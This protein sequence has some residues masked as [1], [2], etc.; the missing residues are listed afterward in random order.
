MRREKLF[1]ALWALILGSLLSCS[2]AMCPVTA[3]QLDIDQGTL[4]CWCLGSA[5][6]C[7]ICFI[8][9]LQPLPFAIGAVSLGYLLQGG[10]LQAGFDAVLNRLSRQY[11]RAYG[12]KILQWSD[13][14]PVEMEP[15]ILI[16]LCIFGALTAMLTAWSVCRRK[17][18]APALFAA[19]IPVGTCFVVTDTVPA[20]G[21]LYLAM[22][23]FLVLLIASGCRK[24]DEKEGNRLM[25]WLLPITALALLVLLAVIPQNS[26]KGQE[27]AKKLASLFH[28]DPEQLL[29]S[30]TGKP[31][32]HSVTDRVDLQSI[33]YRIESDAQIMQVTAPFTGNLYLRG[34]ALDVYDGTSWT[35]G[36]PDYGTLYWPKEGME[37]VGEVTVSTRY[38]HRMLYMPYYSDT[39]Q[40]LDISFGMDND[41]KLNQYSFQC[42][43]PENPAL[44]TQYY[45]TFE[46]KAAP[47]Q[48]ALAETFMQTFPLDEAVLSWSRP[49]A[50]E[51][52][53]PY[54]SPYHKALAISSY[55][56]NSAS[57]NTK[58]NR[59]P[60]SKND[61]AQWFLEESE[62]GYCV[63]FATATVV[64]LQ[65]AG[66]PARYVTG[67]LVPVK[68]GEN[69]VVQSKQSHAWA[70]YWLPGHGWT[71][72]E[73][74]PPASEPETEETTAPT[75]PSSPELEETIPIT[76][77]TESLPP[78]TTTPVPVSKNSSNEKESAIGVILLIFGSIT[79]VIGLLEGQRK[80]RLHSRRKHRDTAAPNDLALLYWAAMVRYSK[81]LKLQ[82][83]EALQDLAQLAKFSQHTVSPEQLDRFAAAEQSA[84][85]ELQRQSVFLRL[86]YRWIL[87]LY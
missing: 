3:F 70:E 71:I 18:T 1:S 29:K 83:D 26:Y 55:V 7:S 65:A 78:E 20:T 51:I 47:E 85:A 84:I 86:Y 69:I 25:L 15:L 30:D 68:A 66:I 16:P 72:L 77:N 14:T 4:L 48:L 2:A 6:L 33:G 80:L 62:T 24:R 13:R 45:P 64:L 63:H 22:L 61:F 49:L 19:L 5:A 35:T 56:R 50:R 32:G 60:G 87:A 44:L 10:A 39:M 46:T 12:W 73:S 37:T 59:M 9:P 34:R 76:P 38:A 79:A 81:L 11:N 54:A 82:P 21:W 75:E 40:L 28:S 36:N 17:T 43:L 41:K 31:G 74:T 42:K 27:T 67:Y 52:T 23:G 57:Y 58:T 8:L 53:G